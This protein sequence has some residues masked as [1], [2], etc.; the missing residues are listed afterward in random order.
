MSSDGNSAAILQKKIGLVV[1]YAHEFNLLG[2]ELS[3]RLVY[4]Y[5]NENYIMLIVKL[6]LILGAITVMS[7]KKT[8]FLIMM[9]VT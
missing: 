3:S 8:V 7:R 1:R 4:E 6:M 5:F 2:A 9:I